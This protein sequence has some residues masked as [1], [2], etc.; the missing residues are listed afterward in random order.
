MFTQAAFLLLAAS[1]VAAASIRERHE[2]IAL[3]SSSSAIARQIHKCHKPP[4]PTVYFPLNFRYGS[5]QKITT[6]LVIPGSNKTMPVCFDQGSDTYWVLEPGAVFNW[7]SEQLGVLGACN[8]SATPVYEY[9]SSLDATD[10]VPFDY[11]NGYSGLSKIVL[12]NTTLEDTMTFTSVAGQKSALPGVRTALANFITVRQPDFSGTCDAS[13]ITYDVGI[14]GIA[15]FQNTSD[16]TTQGPNVRQQ[17]LEDGTIKAPVMSMWMDKRPY[18]VKDTYTGGAIFGG[19]DLTKFTGPLVK[20]RSF[21]NSGGSVGY[22]VAPPVF[23]FKGKKIKATDS[24]SC[25]IDSGTRNDALPVAYEDQDA[26]YKATG[27]VESPMGATSW[28]GTCDTVPS[29]V[30]IDMR[31]PGSKNGTFVDIKI[32]LKNY[33]R[34][35]SGEEGLCRLNIYLG[36]GCTLAAPFSTAAFF[37]AD[38]ERGEVALAQGGISE[39]GSGPSDTAVAL[40]IP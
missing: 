39:R 6:D 27:L 17:L 24:D 26:F 13:E 15:P 10:P 9:L 35:D 22:Y 4:P 23:S 2:P 31:F 25:F 16:Y 32:P 8:I 28:L 36:S 20:V 38:D 40:R 5:D 30:T 33:V 14:M 29:D 1:A 21:E 34:W 19:I 3:R 37:A 12:G 11:F 7:G 18:G